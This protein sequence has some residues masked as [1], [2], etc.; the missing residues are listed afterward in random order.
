MG[1]SSD[2]QPLILIGGSR[3][4]TDSG[5]SSRLRNLFGEFPSIQD[6]VLPQESFLDT[7]SLCIRLALSSLSRSASRISGFV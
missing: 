7:P 6:K 2:T 4:L 3:K 5:S 1:L